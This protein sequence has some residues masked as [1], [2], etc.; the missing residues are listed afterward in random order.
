MAQTGQTHQAT[1][2]GPKYYV[3]TSPLHGKGL[4]ASRTITPGISILE[5]EPTLKPDKGSH[6]GLPDIV[7]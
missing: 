1:H 3:D 2:D 6:N 5:E 7:T 4:F